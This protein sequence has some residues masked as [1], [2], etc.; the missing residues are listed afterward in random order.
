MHF[1]FPPAL[2]LLLDRPGV[3]SRS[4]VQMYRCPKGHITEIPWGADEVALAI[5]GND[6]KFY[7]PHCDES[8]IATR[9]ET[10]SI[11][12]ALGLPPR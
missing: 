12:I 3:G 1:A 7:C 8:R 9:A 10:D 5:E 4:V 2:S 6:L 11:L